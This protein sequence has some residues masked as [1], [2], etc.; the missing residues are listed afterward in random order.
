M[1]TRPGNHQTTNRWWSKYWRAPSLEAGQAQRLG[2]QGITQMQKGTQGL[3]I[4][5]RSGDFSHEKMVGFS[6]SMDWFV[7][8]KLNRKPM[9]FYHQIN[10]L[11]C[12]FSHHPILWVLGK[13]RVGI[14]CRK[15]RSELLRWFY[16]GNLCWESRKYMG[17]IWD[18]VAFYGDS[19]YPNTKS[20]LEQLLKNFWRMDV[21]PPKTAIYFGDWSIAMF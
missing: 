14:S 5:T 7:G 18:F 13:S 21:H 9:G 12:K 17:N 20:R 1:F 10:G 8:E 15:S 3:K 6:I 2:R 19:D 11:S 4:W 16:A